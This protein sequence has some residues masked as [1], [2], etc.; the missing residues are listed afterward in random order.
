MRKGIGIRGWRS[1]L[2]FQ[3]WLMWG[4]GVQRNPVNEKI[5][6]KIQLF[7]SSKQLNQKEKFSEVNNNRSIQYSEIG[8]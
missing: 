7:G 3:R 5:D 1:I 4:V 8:Y 2:R 6:I